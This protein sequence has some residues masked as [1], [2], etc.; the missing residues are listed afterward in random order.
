MA[1]DQAARYLTSETGRRALFTIGALCL[2]RLGS[3]IPLPGLDFNLLGKL[4]ASGSTLFRVSIFALGVTPIFTVMV[5]AE[6]AKSV[7]PPLA[8]YEARGEAKAGRLNRAIQFAALAVAA[9]QGFGIARGLEG[10][11]GIVAEPGPAF[12]LE[13]V[14]TFVAATA[15]LAWLA[16][17]MTARGLGA[18]FWILLVVPYL[19]GLPTQGRMGLE[20]AQAGYM[21]ASALPITIGFVVL[22]IAVIVTLA[23]A[24]L[25]EGLSV[26]AGALRSASSGAAFIDVWPPL[27][28]QAAGTLIG[29]AAVIAGMA[30]RPYPLAFGAPLHIL[31]MAA[32]IAGFSY[33]RRSLPQG[34]AEIRRPPSITALAQIA[35]CCGG[36]WLTR[37][38]GV[39]FAINGAMIIVVV[40][41]ALG[42]MSSER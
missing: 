30:T 37:K 34:A 17:R 8:R 32:L 5:V 12:E 38:L 7:C 3:Q 29:T 20:L 27:L 2:Y 1:S 41:T 26:Q 16:G 25:P 21:D 11:K 42:V 13:V 6:I 4:G 39:P 36:E 19:V 33:L 10:A 28:A 9:L 35:I 14:A 31:L 18:G 22:A 40:A 24:W 15:F 23:L